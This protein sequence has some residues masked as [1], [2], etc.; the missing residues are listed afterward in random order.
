MEFSEKEIAPL[1][2]NGFPIKIKWQGKP[3]LLL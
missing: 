2:S 3:G 1:A